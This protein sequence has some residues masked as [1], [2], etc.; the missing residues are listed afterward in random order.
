MPFE[1]GSVDAHGNP[2]K[3]WGDPVEHAVHGWS[4]PNPVEPKLAGHDRVVVDVEVL[5]PESVVVGPDDRMVVDGKTYD[6][7]GEREDWN[8]SPWGWRPG[9]V[10]NLR[11]VDG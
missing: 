6:V 8:H 11:R 9:F 10:I 2:V 4:I 5:A 7:V 1:P 3:A